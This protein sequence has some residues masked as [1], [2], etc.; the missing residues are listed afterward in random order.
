[1]KKIKYVPVKSS[2]STRRKFFST[3]D[4][5]MES[6]SFGDIVTIYA[7]PCGQVFI[8]DC[9]RLEF[10]EGVVIRRPEGSAPFIIVNNHV[11]CYIEGLVI[12]FDQ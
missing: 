12:E 6:T 4:D 7:G 5:A 1:M 8:K 3:Y 9:I 2:K 11:D 10:E